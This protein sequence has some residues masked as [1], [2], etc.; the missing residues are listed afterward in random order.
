M[1]EVA[2]A[3][4][5]LGIAVHGKRQD[6]YHEISTCM[7]TVDLMDELNVRPAPVARLTCSDPDLSVGAD[8]LVRRAMQ[9]FRAQVREVEPLH[10]HLIKRIPMGAGL[11]GGSADAAATL[12]LLN[13]ISGLPCGADDLRALAARLGSDIPFLVQGGT[14]VARGRGEQLRSVLPED[15]FRRLDTAAAT[16][17]VRAFLEA[18]G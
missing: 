16:A 1:T 8:N 6:G 17:R 9:L 10:L 15:E 14:V 7:Q 12:R 13:R 3:K 11:G 2:W 4:I 18:L 5:N